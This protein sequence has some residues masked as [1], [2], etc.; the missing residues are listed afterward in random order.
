MIEPS[1][2]EIAPDEVSAPEAA[3]SKPPCRIAALPIA[4]SPTAPVPPNVLPALMTVTALAVIRPVTNN[5]PP[6]TIVGPV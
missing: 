3:V 1:P 4:T 2:S 5:F 6:L